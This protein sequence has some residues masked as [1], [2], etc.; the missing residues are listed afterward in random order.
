MATLLERLQEKLRATAAPVPTMQ[1]SM[2]K[3]LQTKRGKA[4]PAGTPAT[5][6]NLAEQATAAEAAS[7]L[8]TQTQKGAA[9][10]DQITEQ[11]RG[12][13]TQAQL[14][15]EQL[16]SQRRVGEAGLATEGRVR[17]GELATTEGLADEQREA[18][19]YTRLSTMTQQADQA[20]T[21]LATDRGITEDQLFG[22]FGRA[23]STLEQEQQKA[24]LDQTLFNTVLSNK[25]YLQEIEELG[26]L[27]RLGDQQA[28]QKELQEIVYGKELAQ[29]LYDVGSMEM[30]DEQG[31]NWDEFLTKLDGD[32]RFE[33]YEKAA[34]NAHKRL[35]W[36]GVS[37]SAADIG[38]TAY[39]SGSSDGAATDSGESNNNSTMSSGGGQGMKA[40]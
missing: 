5:A 38:A 7:A 9:A 10:A 23:R 32:R 3:T 35:M 37:A 25:K 28:F 2:L 24:T 27:R 17:R 20:L 16:A 4:T 19:T 18:Q 8:G 39:K 40:E 13:E 6:S 26:E 29:T 1:E 36:F 21:R 34:E 31:R 22:Q 33:I 15:R 14:E 12:I 11:Q 30:V